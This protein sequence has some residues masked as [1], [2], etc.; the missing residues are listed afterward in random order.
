MDG[1]HGAAGHEGDA[2]KGVGLSAEPDHLPPRLWWVLASLTLAWGFNWTAMKVALAEVPPWTFRS[3]CLG[4]G[5]AV[6][7]LALRA[8][9][10]RIA[11]P[12]GQWG[13]LWLL[14]LLNITS[15][16]M[17][18]AFAVGMIPSGRAAIVAYTMP[19]WAVPLSVW[20]LGERITGRKLVGLA[21]GLGGLAL[22]L[23]ESFAGLGAAPLGSLLVFGA[24][25]SWA[26]GTVLQ[27]RFPVNLPVGPYTAWIMVLGGVPIFAGALAF[28]DWRALREVGVIAWLGTA[29]NVVIAF[30]FA[31][32][33]WIKIATSVPVSV[34][35]I[36]M[37]LIPVV[38]VVSGM[39]F[40][41]ERPTWA[42]YVALAL[43]IVAL[44]TVLR[45][46][47]VARGSA[48][49]SSS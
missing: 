31:H 26:L 13:R 48:R 7:F 33:A 25:V 6:L 1:F 45:P 18:V 41:G 23:L 15:W 38:G 21:L 46:S 44:L 40:L 17:L 2:A 28:E 19:V 11:L 36:S 39:L 4:L 24:A 8:G 43:V 12:R 3:V 37:L 5:A 30:A 32:W 22:L 42:E 35:S 20:L 14:A 16:N 10:Q 29:Y 47:G 9:G 34:F 27:K 49:G